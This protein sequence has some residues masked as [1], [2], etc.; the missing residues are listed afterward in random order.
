MILLDTCTLLWLASDQKRLSKTARERI[1]A[2]QGSLFVCAI[3]A[4]EIGIKH[5]KGALVLPLSPE[6]WY[7][8]ALE[9]HG[10]V[11]VALSGE[12][13]VASTLLPAH[14]PDPCDRFIVATGAHHEMVVLTPDPMI[15]AYDEVESVW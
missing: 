6:R 7:A 10:L 4:F 11:E 13:A 1:R 2:S 3:T 12:I 15:H 9:F 5:R 14:H 8:E